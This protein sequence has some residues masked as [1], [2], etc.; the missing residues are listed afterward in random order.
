LGVYTGSTLEGLTRV[1]EN[2]DLLMDQVYASRVTFQAIAGV[3][4]Q[5]AVDAPKTNQAAGNVVLTLGPPAAP[6][7]VLQ[8]RPVSL[9]EVT[10][11]AFALR[12]ST[13]GASADR[14]QWTLNGQVIPGATNETYVLSSLTSAASGVYSVAVTNDFGGVVSSNAVVLVR[15]PPQLTVDRL[16]P[17]GRLRLRFGESDAT[18]ASDPRFFA[19]QQSRRFEVQSTSDLGNPAAQW[20][21]S[22]GEITFDAGRFWFEES[23]AGSAAQS[24]Y[25]VVELP[26]S[27]LE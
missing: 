16:E 6:V 3:E 27:G 26:G 23:A 13:L 18:V 15:M 19:V 11:V 4:Y 12:V 7:I 14:Y 2:D 8:P 17:D 20:N 5:I 10:N 21:T 24:F 22:P 25:R 1:A 9:V